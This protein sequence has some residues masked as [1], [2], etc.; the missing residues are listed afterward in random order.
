MTRFAG[1]VK[2]FLEEYCIGCHNAEKMKSGVRLDQ[3]DGQRPESTL[4]LWE[5][6]SR[7]VDERE[8]PPEDEAQPSEKERARLLDWIGA[9][10]HEARS[11]DV[12]RDG[13]IRRLTVSQY[14]NTLRR[15]LGLDDDLTDFLP[16]EAVSRDGFKNN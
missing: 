1:E 9:G 8:M 14:R 2:P 4:R 6:V 7:L 3:L 11:R 13:T 12:S 5:H 16:P 10:L 15:L